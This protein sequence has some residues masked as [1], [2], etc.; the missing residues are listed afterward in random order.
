MKDSK[1]FKRNWH[2]HYVSE[3]TFLCSVW[4]KLLLPLPFLFQSLMFL[5][6]QGYGVYDSRR[7]SARSST[8]STTSWANTGPRR[9]RLLYAPLIL[10]EE[11][12]SAGAANVGLWDKKSSPAVPPGT[13]RQGWYSESSV[14]GG[15]QPYRAYT[16]LRVPTQLSPHYSEKRGSADSLVEAVWVQKHYR[17]IIA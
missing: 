15:A 17:H 2:M 11:E 10:V 4:I 1:S 8:C 6:T 14:G 13:V 16:T 9:G 5:P 7:S 12:S 3:W